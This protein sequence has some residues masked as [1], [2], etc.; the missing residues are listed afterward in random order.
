MS[1]QV[2]LLLYVGLVA[3]QMPGVDSIQAF[4]RF[5]AHRIMRLDP[6]AKSIREIVIERRT[7]TESLPDFIRRIRD[8]GANIKNFDSDFSIVKWSCGFVCQDGAVVDS[9]RGKVVFLPFTVTQ[10]RGQEGL[11]LDYR[12]DSRLLVAVG[13]L[14]WRSLDRRQVN[15]DAC[16]KYF[17]EWTIGAFKEIK[18]MS[19]DSK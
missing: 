18:A 7:A 3:A 2:S 8:S 14:E 13:C 11:L 17:F 16:G 12:L 6:S 1:I 19:A 15:R 9:K 5:K 10:E 4:E